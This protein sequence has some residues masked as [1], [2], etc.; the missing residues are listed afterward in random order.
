[1]RANATG[2]GFASGSDTSPPTCTPGA[3]TAKVRSTGGNCGP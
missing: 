2:G 3:G 1:V